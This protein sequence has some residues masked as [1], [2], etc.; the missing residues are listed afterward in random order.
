MHWLQ[1][2]R[3]NSEGPLDRKAAFAL[4]ASWFGPGHG[5]KVADLSSAQRLA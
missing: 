2:G 5:T 3:G 4:R 1:E